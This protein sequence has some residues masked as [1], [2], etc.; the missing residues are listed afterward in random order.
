MAK[1]RGR[2]VNHSY[3]L[4]HSRFVLVDNVSVLC[5]DAEFD[6]RLI[7]F[8]SDTNPMNRKVLMIDVCLFSSLDC[9]LFSLLSESSDFSFTRSLSLS[10]SPL[11]R[12]KYDFEYVCSRRMKK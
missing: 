5:R 9:V 3:G 6:N 8:S 1:A 11:R 10:L 4:S 12:S 2:R 7:M